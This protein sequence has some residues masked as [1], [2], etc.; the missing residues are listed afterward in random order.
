MVQPA[1]KTGT[2]R[3]Q[4][5]KL[6]K[7]KLTNFRCYKDEVVIDL[8]SLVVFVGKN[9]AGKSS[10][11]E[12][13][14][15]F[16]EG[17]TAP[18]KDDACVHAEDD[19]VRIACV[20]DDVPSELVIDAQHPTDLASEHLLNSEGNRSILYTLYPHGEKWYIRAVPSS[21]G[22]FSNKKNLPKEWAGLNDGD[23]SKAAG[24][25]DGI[26]CHHSLFICAANSHA[27]AIQLIN[28]A[29]AYK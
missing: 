1:S 18:D 16:F 6:V 26:F 11:F 7:L 23:F 2:R 21:L 12:S 8:D 4:A 13:L 25:A 22:K 10:L 20:F 24:I 14:D 15:I 27:S 28:K 19:T 5:V 3:N 17:K 9:D 29:V